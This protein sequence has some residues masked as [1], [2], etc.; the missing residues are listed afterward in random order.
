MY[1]KKI[2]LFVAVS[3]LASSLLFT[4]CKKDSAKDSDVE[5]A[6]SSALAEASFNDVTT[7]ADQA[8]L[9][10]S[11]NMR[12]SGDA[13]R[14][15]GSLGSSCATVSIDTVSVPHVIVIDFGSS[16]CVC[17]DG[18][19]RRG[20]INL[21]YTGRYKDAGTVITISFTNYF[22]NDNQLT[23]TKKITNQGANAAGNLVY[24]IEVN[25]QVIKANNGGTISWVSTRQREWTAGANTPLILSDDAYSITGSA[26]G[27]VASGKSYSIVIKSPLVR[28]MSCH[29]F[30]SGVVE[31]T[32]EGK[33]TRTLDYGNTGCDANAT[34][35]ILGYTFPIILR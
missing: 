30:E 9:G 13:N 16:N 27:T 3:V 4:S 8:A 6:E 24:K 28:K 20:K 10:G 2:S 1:A 25:G 11:V 26:T 31:V 34:V 15:D 14:E 33:P 29:F 5:S 21:S 19:T 18:R 22:V 35:S 12:L 7:I 17:N 23:G 32:P